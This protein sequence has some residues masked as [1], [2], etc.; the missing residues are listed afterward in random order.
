MALFQRDPW[1]GRELLRTAPEMPELVPLRHLLLDPPQYGG[2]PASAP[3]DVHGWLAREG[4]DHRGFYVA[5]DHGKMVD[6]D[7]DARALDDRLVRGGRPDVLVVRVDDW[8]RR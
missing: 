2:E 3:N 6:R 7:A 1:A 5:I 8:L 4:A